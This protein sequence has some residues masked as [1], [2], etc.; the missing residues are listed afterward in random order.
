[1]SGIYQFGN[2]SPLYVDA[3]CPT[4]CFGNNEY[5]DLTDYYGA[6]PIPASTAV[7]IYNTPLAVNP[8]TYQIQTSA[9]ITEAD[10]AAA[11]AQAQA[12]ANKAAEMKAQY[13]RSRQM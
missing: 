1:M 13:I 7:R 12:A 10:V 4:Q 8:Q 3:G 5:A 2:V 9:K 6:V 11:Q